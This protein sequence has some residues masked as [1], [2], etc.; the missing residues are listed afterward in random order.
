[1][2]V[3][4]KDLTEKDRERLLE[5]AKKE[6]KSKDEQQM[7]EHRLAW[8]KTELHSAQ[9]ARIDHIH[10]NDFYS[11]HMFSDR[12]KAVVNYLY[13]AVNGLPS[14]KQLKFENDKQ[15]DLYRKIYVQFTDFIISIYDECKM[16]LGARDNVE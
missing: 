1:M 2:K 6:I 9:E 14:N 5:E 4:L 10:C 7:I 12:I 15:F 8:S 11:K 16:E 13:K 3:S